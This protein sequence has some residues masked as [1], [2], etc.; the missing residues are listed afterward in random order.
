MERAFSEFKESD[1]I[2]GVGIGVNLKIMSIT[3]ALVTVW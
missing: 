2:E 3:C 1:K